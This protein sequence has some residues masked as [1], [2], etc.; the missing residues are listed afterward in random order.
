MQKPIM[1]S[2]HR[3]LAIFS[4]MSSNIVPNFWSTSLTSSASLPFISSRVHLSPH[5]LSRDDFNPLNSSTSWAFVAKPS[6]VPSAADFSAASLA[7]MV[8]ANVLSR[9]SR[10]II[11]VPTSPLIS[12]FNCSTLCAWL[13]L[14]MADCSNPEM[15]RPIS[16]RNSTVAFWASARYWSNEAWLDCWMEAINSDLHLLTIA[17]ASS[18]VTMLVFNLSTSA[19]NS[20]RAFRSAANSS[21]NSWT[22]AP[23]S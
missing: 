6:A 11:A 1:P 2:Y 9:S 21:R 23:I 17:S 10:S 13:W 7:S 8:A 22:A 19:C 20:S 15:H 14:F 16:S 18:L 3:I 12:T 4:S 5:S